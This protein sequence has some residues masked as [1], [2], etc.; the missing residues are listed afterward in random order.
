VKRFCEFVIY[1]YRSLQFVRLF[2][3]LTRPGDSEAIFTVFKASSQA[4]TWLPVP[5]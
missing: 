3:K 4:A 5:Y 1:R 2:G